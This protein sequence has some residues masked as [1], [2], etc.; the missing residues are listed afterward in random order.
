MDEET[1]GK[2]RGLIRR[3]VIRN[4]NDNGMT[5]T[6]SA[7]VTDGI[8]RDNVEIAQ[9]Y[10][11]NSHTPEDGALGIML[12]NGGDEGDPVILPLGNPSNRM[13]GLAAGDVALYNKGGDRI[14]LMADGTLDIN[15]G[16][17]AVL[18]IPG[19]MVIE[20]PKVHITGDLEVDGEVRDHTG[21]MQKMRDQYNQHGHIGA[22]PPPGPLMD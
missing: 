21:T 9:I 11:L 5:Q 14:V 15:I 1:A 19:G 13:G 20:T 3:V 17:E 2:L 7:E 18:V 22:A 8:W 10:G 12:A 6:A 4:I 16:G